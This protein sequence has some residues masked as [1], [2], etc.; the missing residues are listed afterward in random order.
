MIF[1]LTSVVPVAPNSIVSPG[2]ICAVQFECAGSK[3]I[4]TP[5]RAI[6]PGAY[7]DRSSQ[8]FSS[9]NICKRNAVQTKLTRF[10]ACDILSRPATADGGRKLRNAMLSSTLS[11]SSTS[12]TPN[13]TAALRFC[14]SLPN[15]ASTCLFVL[16]TGWGNQRPDGAASAIVLASFAARSR[17]RAPSTP[18]TITR[19]SGSVPD[20]RNR[21][22]PLPASESSAS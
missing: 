15:G 11:F 17:I 14:S 18:S 13:S 21:T 4:L 22:R 6:V 7:G 3:I 19:M 12:D 9:K 16:P 2:Y 10:D 5:S 8:F 1:G 20:A